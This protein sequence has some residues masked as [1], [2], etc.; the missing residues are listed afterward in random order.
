MPSTY[1]LISSN[2][3]SSSAA[4]VTFSAI[5]STYT[6]LVLR[7]S[8][9]TDAAGATATVAAQFNGDT[10][11][12]NYSETNINSDGAAAYSD[13]TARGG[14]WFGI[15]NGNGSTAS[16]FT[17]A[18]LYIPSYTAAQKKPAS[19]ITAF[20]T[21]ATTAYITAVANLYGITTAISS[22]N[23]YAVAGSNFVSGSSFYLY[24]ISKS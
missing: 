7:V 5:P 18:E 22:I 14:T 12:A 16:T 8:T 4:S 21:N 15:T 1:T 17:S 24:G 20:E 3:L 10:T 23:V 19:V 11:S 6:D 13:R 2:V 9:R